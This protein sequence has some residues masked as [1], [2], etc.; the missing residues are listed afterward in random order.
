MAGGKDGG[1]GRFVGSGI[2]FGSAAGAGCTGNATGT[3]FLWHPASKPTS[4]TRTTIVREG[5]FSKNDMNC[6]ADQEA[7]VAEE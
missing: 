6:E 2:S 3:R 4:S 5:E 7:T 1:G